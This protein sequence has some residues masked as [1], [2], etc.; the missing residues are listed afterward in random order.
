MVL[1]I[2]RIGAR[3]RIVV[4]TV[5]VGVAAGL[6]GI[7]L[8]A[9]LHLAQHLA[10]GYTE[11]S[12]LPG[13]QHASM[14][15]RILALTTGGLLVG[16]GWWWLD[17]WARSEDVSVKAAITGDTPR[18]R[19]RASTVD[20]V[21]QVIGVG[22]GVSL[23][24]EGAPRQV[25]AAVAGWIGER[26]ELEPR[27]RRT[28]IA[29]GAGAGL[30]AVYNVPVSGV[31]FTLEVLLASFA[32]R[33]LLPAVATSVIATVITW[34]VL[35]TRPT[36]AVT[37]E[38]FALPVLVWAVLA[39]PVIGIAGVGFTALMRVAR[40][41]TPSGRRRVA[42]TILS[43]TLVG[44][45]ATVYPQVLGNGKGPTQV[46]FAGGMTLALAAALCLLKPL[47]TAL[48]LAGGSRGGLLTPSLSTG[49]FLGIATGLLWQ[50]LWPGTPVVD[51]AVIGA[52][53][54]LAVTQRA[55]LIGVVLTC[56]FIRGG[57]TL[58]PAIVC[59]VALA[60]LTARVVD[61]RSPRVAGIGR[62]RV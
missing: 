61:G 20:A 10:F 22:A 3:R 8:T 15:R 53:A 51:F 55:P 34:P 6:G 38:R 30:A 9:V 29:C 56:E 11:E 33:D 28:L 35:P 39:G 57:F 16:F 44:V 13:V 43:L 31:F 45:L 27:T 60:T 32:L 21:L 1:L 46:A 40:G 14:A 26:L 5:F 18:L 58:L 2:S 59:C 12:F 37:G 42:A 54:M 52:A 49:A 24:R 23:G 7:A 62:L 36:Y 4:A 48:C 41:W 47:A 25:G 19:V 17:R 50:H